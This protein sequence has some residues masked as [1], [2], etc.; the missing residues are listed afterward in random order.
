MAAL[1]A[2][3]IYF[4]FFTSKKGT[5]DSDE[6]RMLADSPRFTLSNIWSGQFSTD[7]ESFLS[8]HSPSRKRAISF[9]NN[10]RNMVSAA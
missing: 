1:V 7:T 2:L 3:G 5:F 9:C 4:A 10:L 8:D 6:N